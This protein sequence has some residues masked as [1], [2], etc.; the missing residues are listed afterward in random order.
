MCEGGGCPN[1]GRSDWPV[2][3]K[4][5]CPD[6]GKRAWPVADRGAWP[7]IVDAEAP[8]GGRSEGPV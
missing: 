7:G 8:C 3:G 5:G 1:A 6:A 2:E 4:S